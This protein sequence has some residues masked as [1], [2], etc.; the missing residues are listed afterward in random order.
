[1]K[2]QK[3]ISNLNPFK[4]KPEK[5]SLPNK[6]YLIRRNSL[7]KQLNLED[8]ELKIVEI[9]KKG[10]L[11]ELP[12]PYTEELI[13]SLEEVDE[14]TGTEEEFKEEEYEF[15]D[16]VNFGEVEYRKW[17]VKHLVGNRQEK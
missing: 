7:A 5:E 8:S 6:F 17:E 13:N 1:M 11:S 15:E 3:I 9:Y 12:Q 16:T 14:M 10:K 2:I 4:K